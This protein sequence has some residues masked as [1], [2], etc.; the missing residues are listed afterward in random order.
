MTH[1]IVRA[2]EQVVE[3]IRMLERIGL[4]DMNGHLSARVP[5]RSDRFFI[6]ARGTSRAVVSTHDLAVCDMEGRPEPG[7]PEPPSEVFIHSAILRRRPEVGAVL[8]NHP[9]WQIVLGIAGVSP[10]P[11]FSIG[12]FV[13]AATP[14]YEHSSLVN[15]PEMG[16]ELADVLGSKRMAHIRHH[17]AVYAGATVQEVFALAVYAEENAKKQYQAALLN[18]HHCVLA[19]E[20]LAR[21]RETNWTPKIVQKVWTYYRDKLLTCEGE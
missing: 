7:S 20:N 18:P 8:H 2:K 21:T 1:E 3:A 16:E 13:D 17:G 12:A 4:L 10:Q 9:H 6:N 5:G 19:G 11:V 15:T 14:V